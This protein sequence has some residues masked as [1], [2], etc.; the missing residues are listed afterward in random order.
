MNNSFYLEDNNVALEA[1]VTM[2]ALTEDA[3]DLD[4]VSG[5]ASVFPNPKKS[6]D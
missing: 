1:D 4:G 3:L 6:T 5:D 2:T